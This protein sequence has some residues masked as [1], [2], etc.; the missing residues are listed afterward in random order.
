MNNLNNDGLFEQ[1]LQAQETQREGWMAEIPTIAPTPKTD[2]LL[3]GR[4]HGNA[5]EFLARD[6]ERE[7]AVKDTEIDR[8][9]KE[10]G[11]AKT[12]ANALYNELSQLTE[13]ICECD[14]SKLLA[15]DSD[16]HPPSV[17]HVYSK[18]AMTVLAKHEALTS[19][20]Q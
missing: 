4:E 11:E 14:E 15:C 9:K 5:I 8:L 16:P 7:L 19:Q 13:H 12:D 3:A 1:V 2:E 10:L 17:F 18:S 6:L 20:R